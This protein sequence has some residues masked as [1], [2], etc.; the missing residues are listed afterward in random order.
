MSL[1]NLDIPSILKEIS[2]FQKK[3]VYTPKV[4]IPK[5]YDKRRLSNVIQLIPLIG[6]NNACKNF[7][8]NPTI[9][10]HAIKAR[11]P[12]QWK[13]IKQSGR[14]KKCKYCK[15]D[16]LFSATSQLFCCNKCRYD[17][18]TDQE[19]FGGK[20]LKTYG[21]SDR[22]CQVCGRKDSPG[23]TPHHILGKE[24]DPKDKYLVSIC[25]GCHS[26]I[27]DLGRRNFLLEK[28]KIELLIKLAIIRKLAD[29]SVKL[30][31]NSSVRVDLDLEI[32]R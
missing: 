3:P 9:F 22:V 17:F 12:E 5:G 2:S 25:R 11:L 14:T 15:N 24:N 29:N 13:V 21:L 31:F 7:D 27:T 16:F 1:Y 6:I 30:L 20:K 10:G 26:L 28:E 4:K 23:L 32:E 8:L 19:Y 18:K